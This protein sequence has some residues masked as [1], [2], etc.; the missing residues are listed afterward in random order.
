MKSERKKRE[1]RR[2]KW[3]DSVGTCIRRRTDGELVE[4]EGDYEGVEEEGQRR[5][6]PGHA[7]S[8]HCSEEERDGLVLVPVCGAAVW[9]AL[10]S[11]LTRVWWSGCVRMCVFCVPRQEKR[12]SAI[13]K[14]DV[15]SCD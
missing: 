14:G 6:D 3:I 2:R 9:D 8:E 4:G 1:G 7:P 15:G 11:I 10:L 5:S 13:R 12:A